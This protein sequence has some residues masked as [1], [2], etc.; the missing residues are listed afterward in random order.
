MQRHPRV[1]YAGWCGR[2]G[3]CRCGRTG[4]RGLLLSF[5]TRCTT[6]RTVSP[7]RSRRRASS[8]RASSM[9]WWRVLPQVSDRRSSTSRREQPRC[10]ATSSGERLRS[11]LAEM[12]SSAAFASRAAV[13]ERAVDSPQK[14]SFAGMRTSRTR[15]FHFGWRNRKSS[16]RTAVLPTRLKSTMTLEML[17]PHSSWRATSLSTPMTATCSGTAIPSARQALIT[18][19]A[20]LSETAMTAAGFGSPFTH[21]RNFSEKSLKSL[22]AGNAEVPFPATA[23]ASRKA[24]RRSS[25]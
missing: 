22:S 4:W 11:L 1:P 8:I 18:S 16:S 21:F 23:I 12:K 14:T 6:A 5:S 3:A 2:S 13:G 25:E 20:R 19:A 9:V 7:S 10:A 15:P 17:M 24:H